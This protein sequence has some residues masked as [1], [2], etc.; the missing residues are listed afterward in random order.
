[1]QS[2]KSIKTIICYLTFFCCLWPQD[3]PDYPGFRGLPG[4]VWSGGKRILSLD[5]GR[6]LEI[7][8]QTSGKEETLEEPEGALGLTYRAGVATTCRLVDKTILVSQQRLP[9]LW[10]NFPIDFGTFGRD[11][12]FGLPSKL[13]QTDTGSRFFVMDVMPGFS[14]GEDASICSWWKQTNGGVFKAEALIPIALDVPVFQAFHPVGPGGAWIAQ[15]ALRYQG[16]LPFLEFPIQVKGAFLV[17]SWNAGIIWVIKDDD[18]WPSRT[19]KLLP[20]DD[21]CLSGRK[22]HSPVLLG[23]Q[24]MPNDRVLVAMRTRK[25][26]EASIRLEQAPRSSVPQPPDGQGLDEI[27][28]KEVD[29]FEGRVGDPDPAV[30]ERAPTSWPAGETL[31]F[32]FDLAGRL[33]LP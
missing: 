11:E 3:P 31:A 19:I 20:L 28:W 2:T 14:K 1:M 8:D 18:P 4:L 29:P 7:A 13:Y 17:V 9:G 22:R 26:I 15:V 5:F 21:D 25:A 12:F 27:E 33:I 24:P 6:A 10:E 30:L 16:L 23:I 32:R